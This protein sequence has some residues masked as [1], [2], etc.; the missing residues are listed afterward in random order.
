MKRMGKMAI[1]AAFVLVSGPAAS[2]SGAKAAMPEWLAGSWKTAGT[3][4]E[5]AE[6]WWTPPKAGLMM[7]AARS[8]KAD[9]LGDFEHMRIIAGPAGLQFCAVPRGQAGA[10]FDAVDVGD[11]HITFENAKHDYPTRITYR[12]EEWGISA[13]ITGPNGARPQNWRYVPLAN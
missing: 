11:R 13:E 8:G 10:C 2:A 12:R 1:A 4:D 6:E 3:A 7:G 9:A 5:W